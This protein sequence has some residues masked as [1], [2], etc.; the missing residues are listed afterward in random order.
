VAAG[1]GGGDARRGEAG[2]GRGGQGRSVESRRE[3]GL[4][5][6]TACWTGPMV[7]DL[8]QDRSIRCA[9]TAHTDPAWGRWGSR[10]TVGRSHSSGQIV[11]NFVTYF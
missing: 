8:I 6:Q 2:A 7:G 10:V 11:D 9:V 5:H 4:D 1:A 3:R